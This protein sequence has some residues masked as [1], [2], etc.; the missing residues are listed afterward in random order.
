[1]R[2]LFY[3][4][5]LTACACSKP[6]IQEIPDVSDVPSGIADV[7]FDVSLEVPTKTSLGPE[8]G[9]F[10]PVLWSEGDCI[11]VNGRG[12]SA[13][14]ADQAGKSTAT[15]KVT[16]VSAPY[17]IV[18]PVS[19]MFSDGVILPKTQKF[20][21][22]GFDPAA[23]IQVCKASSLSPSLHNACAYL[24]ITLRKSE[25]GETVKQIKVISNDDK[26]LCGRFSIDYDNNKLKYIEAGMNCVVMGRP[27]DDATVTIPYNEDGTCTAFIAIPSGEYPSG[28]TVV[29]STVGSN[30]P[31]ANMVKQSFTKGVTMAPGSVHPLEEVSFS[32]D[33]YRFSGGTGTESDPYLIATSDDIWSLFSYSNHNDYSVNYSGKHYKQ[34]CD[35]TVENKYW[36]SAF[37]EP[38]KAFTGVYDGGGHMIEYLSVKNYVSGDDKYACGFFA[39]TKD[40]TFKNLDIRY[41]YYR[42]NPQQITGNYNGGFI[43]HMDGGLIENCTLSGNMHTGPDAAYTGGIVGYLCGGGVVSG[44]LVSS[45]VTADGAI[46][47]SNYMN[48]HI[49]GIVGYVNDGIVTDCLMSGHVRSVGACAGGIVGSLIKGNVT[50]CNVDRAYMYG[51]VARVGGVAGYVGGA[52]CV[53]E[54]CQM[55]GIVLSKTAGEVGGIAGYI[56]GGRIASCQVLKPAT[57]SGDGGSVGGVA[58]NVY[59]STSANDI[60]IDNCTVYADVTGKMNVGG[61]AGTVNSQ[62][63]SMRIINN[64]YAHGTITTTLHQ[65]GAANMGGIVGVVTTTSNV[66][67][68][69]MNNV[70]MMTKFKNTATVDEITS[71]GGIVGAFLGSGAIS[72]CWSDVM[73]GNIITSSKTTSKL[74]SIVGDCALSTLPHC[75]Y[76]ENSTIKATQS[77]N[78]LGSA[79]SSFTDGNVLSRLNWT[80]G[81]DSDLKPWVN[82]IWT[83]SGTSYP[84]PQGIVSN[85][86]QHTSKTKRISV[87]GDSISSF[88]GYNPEGYDAY[89]PTTTCRTFCVRDMYWYRL[90]YDY[91][92]DA[93]LDVNIAFSGSLV[94]YNGNWKNFPSR[95]I[96]RK[97]MGNPD[98]ILLWGGTN[99]YTANK[100]LYGTTTCQEA[101]SAPSN[102]DLNTV[103]ATT[104]AATTMDKAE[105]LSDQTFFEAYIKLVKMMTL[106]Y[107]K[108]KIVLIV[109]EHFSVGMKETIEAIAGHYPNNCRVI[110]LLSING[111]DGITT[112][113]DWR[114][115]GKCMD[116]ARNLHP[117]EAGM[118]FIANK[119]YTELGSWLEE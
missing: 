97:G 68:S 60:T 32:D 62:G 86:G 118:A 36:V 28:F 59:S 84:T 25:S 69:V 94:T 14:T 8:T 81:K 24:R 57:V 15:F 61:I 19:A 90:A 7:T 116:G 17:K 67:T 112:N 26:F 110:D 33:T 88:D 45:S 79:T 114:P 85:E 50:G 98:I 102:S 16:Q 73:I 37:R 63:G 83:V 22:W 95:Y 113:P 1:M 100:L 108:V 96:L 29:I 101:S 46:A 106:Q 39:Y 77:K 43:G 44:C 75:Y 56:R 10:Y 54:N 99:D 82:T 66:A 103:F 52:G 78:G 76:N 49:G 72:W 53:I 5:I 40:A 93:I 41:K 64:A 23:A 31:G 38:S 65:L 71:I 13:L 9:N 70:C 47:E 6:Q 30:S 105:A 117:N 104:D 2:R 91:M 109:G 21:E 58:G 87:I 74:G 27:E 92:K 80:T 48:S 12:S 11:S 42:D 20:T 89:Y 55:T 3:L 18:Y 115:I 34:I 35:I 119:I 4:L 107:P 51:D 111:F